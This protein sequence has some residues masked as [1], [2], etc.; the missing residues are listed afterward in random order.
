V[1][2]FLAGGF[3]MREG[4]HL[5]SKERL[6]MKKLAV[7]VG[8]AVLFAA[9][10]VTAMAAEVSGIYKQKME[11]ARGTSE[12]TITLK[13]AGDKVTGT[14]VRV[15]GEKRVEQEIKEGKVSGDQVEFKVETRMGENTVIGTYKAKVTDEGLEGT[16]AMG[17]KPPR[18][19]KA[20]RQK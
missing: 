15:F 16:V 1:N 13:Q 8:L 3:I 14:L 19:F 4:V 6:A 10:A 12:L 9:F 11:T 17:E 18:D 5:K 7:F 20:A 2:F